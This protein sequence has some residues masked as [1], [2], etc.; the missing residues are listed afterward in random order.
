MRN[1]NK[2]I[3]F[4]SNHIQKGTRGERRLRPAPSAKVWLALLGIKIELLSGLPLHELFCFANMKN[5][6]SSI[7][8]KKKI[9]VIA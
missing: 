6:F 1:R 4:V 8:I 9:I 3:A 5:F 2:L 7:S